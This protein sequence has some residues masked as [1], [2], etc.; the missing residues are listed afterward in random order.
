MGDDTPAV[1]T[2][3]LREMGRE[4]RRNNAILEYTEFEGT[5]IRGCCMEVADEIVTRLSEYGFAKDCLHKWRCQVGDAN[6]LHYAVALPCD[7]VTDIEAD[8]GL[9][10]V[11]ATLDQFCTEQQDLGRVE[12]AFGA[13]D[14]LPAVDIVRPD[15]DRRV[16]YQPGQKL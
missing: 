2:E 1:T 6:E 3:E 9:L 5:K 7:A 15:E 12:T 11:D 16:R 14:D 4:A 8:S 13:Y 10:I